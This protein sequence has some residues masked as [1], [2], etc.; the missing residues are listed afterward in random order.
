MFNKKCS[1]CDKKVDRG[2]DFCPF[3]GNNLTRK[4]DY[5]I[6]GKND[7]DQIPDLLGGSMMDKLFKTAMKMVE[8][9]MKF[10][11]EENEKV[12][13]K[14]TSNV[15][16]QFYINGKKVNVVKPKQEIKQAPIK[17]I[18]ELTEEQ[19]KKLS[20]LPRKEPKTKMTRLSGRLIYELAV[21]GVE[22]INDVLINQ[23]ETSIEIKAITEKKI[24]SKTINVNL[25][26]LGYKLEKPNLIIE[27]QAK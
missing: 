9:Q 14:N 4:E 25:P 15:D 13:K 5:G 7:F 8:N 22:N 20:K 12:Q 16:V 10:M 6:L 3:C 21:P 19:T 18:K 2:Y 23:L 24:Y 1:K 26:V 17:K 27:L 11:T